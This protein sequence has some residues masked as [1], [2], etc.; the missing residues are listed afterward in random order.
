MTRP[1]LSAQYISVQFCTP[2]S[3]GVISQYIFRFDIRNILFSLKENIFLGTMKLRQHYLLISVFQSKC[4]YVN[5]WDKMVTSEM[6]KRKS[7]MHASTR[8]SMS[9]EFQ[10]I[11]KEYPILFYTRK[12]WSFIFF[13]ITYKMYETDL[14]KEKYFHLS[15]YSSYIVFSVLSCC[16]MCM[17]KYVDLFVSE[18]WKCFPTII[19]C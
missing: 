15:F 11:Y 8:K 18:K 10:Q 16:V 19:V 7:T 13:S 5:I 9:T 17:V 4:T 12:V 6:C 3:K 1:C 14:N 2:Q